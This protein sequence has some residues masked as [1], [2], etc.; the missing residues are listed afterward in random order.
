MPLKHTTLKEYDADKYFSFNYKCFLL[1][2]IA[3]DLRQYQAGTHV[4]SGY[5]KC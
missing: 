3:F 5:P 4:K 1:D 2:L